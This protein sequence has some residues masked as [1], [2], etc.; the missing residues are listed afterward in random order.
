MKIVIVGYGKMGHTIEHLALKAGH[1]VVGKIDDSKSLTALNVIADV[2]IDFTDAKAWAENYKMLADK[3]PAVVVG[4]TGWEREAPEVLTY[5]KEK[6]KTLIHSSNFALGVN[7]FWELLEYANRLLVNFAKYDPYILEMHHKQKK[8]AP[9][10]TAKKMAEILQLTSSIKV[11]PVSVRAGEIK[12]VHEAGF[13]TEFEGIKIR[14][15][16]YSRKA[17]AEG[18]LLAVDWTKNLRGVWSFSDLMK[19][20]IKE[21]Y[22]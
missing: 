18:A 2:A 6:Q 7:L 9:S 22:L 17:F 15:E 10:G 12:G 5:F 3:F 14:H 8:D 19:Q 13:E 4:T 16:A 21:F 1:T 20:K 11:T